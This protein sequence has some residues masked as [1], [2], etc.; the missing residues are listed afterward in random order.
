MAS[1][2]YKIKFHKAVVKDVKRFSFN[3]QQKIRTKHLPK[4]IQNP[5]FFPAL[6]GKL[7]NYRKYS[8]IYRKTDYRIIYKVERDILT[9][10]IIMIGSRE[11]FY[12]RLIRRIKSKR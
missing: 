5:F 3:L 8:F 2:K 7:K 11:E 12:K 9:V 1:D 10:I 6:R 4:I